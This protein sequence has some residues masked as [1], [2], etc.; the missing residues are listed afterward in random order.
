M[1]LT[2]ND[3]HDAFAIDSLGNSRENNSVSF[4]DTMGI[5]SYKYMSIMI[6][7]N[8]IISIGKTSEE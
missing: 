6:V 1:P 3:R 2:I 4:N 8:V 5:W 7:I